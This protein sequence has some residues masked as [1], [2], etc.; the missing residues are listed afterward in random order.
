MT[1][2]EEEDKIRKLQFIKTLIIDNYDSYT[3]NLLQLFDNDKNVMVIRNDQFTWKEFTTKILPYFDNIIISPGPGRPERSQD[4]GIC[5][6]LL[7]A[8]L[9]SEHPEYH[10]PIFGICLGHQGIGHLFGG[11]VIHAPRIMHGRMS[12]IHHKKGE[13]VL[14][15]DLFHNCP[16]S[17]WAVRYHSLVVDKNSLPND[18]VLTAFCYE[19]DADIHA[20][21]NASFLADTEE[22]DNSIKENNRRHHF[23][24]HTDD[25]LSLDNN[26]QI[27][28][29]GFQH[30][31]L[32]IWGV[33]FHP[34]SVSTECGEKMIFNFQKETYHW[35]L[36]NDNR[37]LSESFLSPELLSYSVTS[38]KPII[39]QIQSMNPKMKL[40]IKTSSANWVEPEAFVNDFLSNKSNLDKSYIGWLDSSRK[41][42]PYSQYSLL[43]IDPAMI[44][45]YSTLHREVRINKRDEAAAAAATTTTI[46][47]LEKEATFF[48]YIANMLNQCNQI[49]LHPIDDDA[50]QI[51]DSRLLEFQGG[52]IGYFGYEMKRESM[53]GYRTPK[54][55]H[56]SCS[57]Q[58]QQNCCLC[59]EEPDAA[60]QFVDR[61]FIFDQNQ[62]KVY[63]CCLVIDPHPDITLSSLFDGIFQQHEEAMA[64]IDAQE[65]CMA[66]VAD[67]VHHHESVHSFTKITPSS[68]SSTLTPYLASLQDSTMTSDEQGLFKADT[69][70]KSYLKAIESC[71]DHIR[72]GESYEICLTTRFRLELSRKQMNHDALWQLYT[73]YLRKNN[74][75][76]FS[77]LLMFPQLSLLSSSPERFL[78]IKDGIAEMKPIKGTVGRVLSCVCPNGQCDLGKRCQ[79]RKTTE[80][81]VRKQQ[82]WQDVK[83]RAEN[84]MIVDLIRNDLAQVCE[85][86]SVRVPKLMHVET[87]EK[88]H[89]LVSTIRGNLRSDV[90]TVDALRKCFPPGSMTGAPKLRSVQILDELERHRPRG[91]YSGCLG[92]FSLGNGNADFNV[93]IRTAVASMKSNDSIK[94]SVGGGGAITYLSNPEQ[95]WKETL[96][97]TKSVAPSIKEYIDNHK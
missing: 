78:K 45:S 3:F 95:E 42:S 20:L 97:K 43:S 96:L 89:H 19:N 51:N 32:P 1:E 38:S 76:P 58:G 30:K 25:E 17:F 35:L 40:Y 85:P 91:V 4:F 23:L 74:P 71:I 50:R 80:D 15:G 92:Y 56:C 62:Q 36:V 16:S 2:I 81:N 67:G 75:A 27:T 37:T 61:F 55:Q 6:Q 44:V 8:Q 63:L 10:R 66:K 84:L 41:S 87:Y 39:N 29:M 72:E 94:I 77:A 69:E 68:S 73:Y 7:E 12:Q 24:K 86:S 11:K 31:T 52:L 59:I 47:Y 13:N 90:N 18:L 26:Q 34:E 60:F 22:S 28:I 49:D 9:N 79:E 82:L 21:K 48:D 53:E 54:E 14:F 33:Q 65:E 88:V 46:D 83:E 93:V 57:H 70:H 64:W 5:T